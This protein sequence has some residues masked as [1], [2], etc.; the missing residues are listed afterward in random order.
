MWGTYDKKTNFI[1][2]KNKGFKWYSYS[3]IIAQPTQSQKN[4]EIQIIAL[5]SCWCR[6]SWGIELN[7]LRNESNLFWKQKVDGPSLGR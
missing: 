2:S 6:R 7:G 1:I 4:D 5:D 3:F